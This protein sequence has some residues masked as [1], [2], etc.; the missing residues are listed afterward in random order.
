[1]RQS[2]GQHQTHADVVKE[3]R[4]QKHNYVCSEERTLVHRG[5]LTRMELRAPPT[6]AL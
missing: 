6:S 4:S 3:V 5:V 2:R 1:M